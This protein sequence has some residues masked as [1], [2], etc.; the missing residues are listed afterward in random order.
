MWRS[1]SYADALEI[2]TPRERAR[3]IEPSKPIVGLVKFGESNDWSP[4]MIEFEIP[5]KCRVVTYL[6]RNA[7]N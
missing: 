4:L 6:F 2:D 3:N 5:G 7:L 1:H